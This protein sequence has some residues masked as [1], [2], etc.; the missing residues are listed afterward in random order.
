MADS[1]RG[2]KHVVI[3]V[4]EDVQS[5]DFVGPHEVFAGAQKLTD[6]TG[7]RESGYTIAV[8]SPDGAPIATSGGLRIVPD[9]SLA[10]AP[11]QIDTLLVPGGTG[12]GAASADEELLD[13]VRVAAKHARRVT[14]VCTG[15]F[16]LAAAGLLDGRRATTHWAS[17][18]RLA[19]QYPAVEV[20]ADAIYVH[21]GPVWTSAGVTA[22][23]DLALALVEEDLD[24]EAALTIARNL[25]LSLR[26]PDDRSQSS[27][28]LA[29]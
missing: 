7:R 15:A 9:A 16:V 17:V 2:P 29:L 8:V 1:A 11:E 27:A 20:D 24:R 21:D 4:F 5:L 13:W 12:S 19:E 22:G 25:G 10:E 6:R 18:A 26:G 28:T 3:V 23:M 14:S